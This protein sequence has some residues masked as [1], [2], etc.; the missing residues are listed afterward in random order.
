MKFLT[1]PLRWWDKCRS[2]LS[3]L[4]GETHVDKRLFANDRTN[5]EPV[6]L[7]KSRTSCGEFQKEKANELRHEF[8]TGRL[9]DGRH[10]F[11]AAPLCCRLPLTWMPQRMIR[12][13]DGILPITPS[14][15]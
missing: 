7:P 8:C 14:S 4:E 13:S 15:S 5:Q 3:P 11:I 12:Y 10:V 1:L 2:A 6:R 9:D